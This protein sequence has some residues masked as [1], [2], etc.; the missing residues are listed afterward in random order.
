MAVTPSY[1]AGSPVVGGGGIVVAGS[2]EEAAGDPHHPV[3][4]ER[5]CA[6]VLPSPRMMSFS[7][8]QKLP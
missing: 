7:H 2:S 4:F 3:F 6:A 1:C 8:T 5:G